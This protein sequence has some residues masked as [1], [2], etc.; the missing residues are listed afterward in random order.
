M[1]LVVVGAGLYGLAVARAALAAGHDVTVIEQG[2]APNP[3]AASV[4]RH[5]L[6]RYPYG[7]ER[8]YTAMVGEAFAAWEALWRSL[9]QRLYHETG[10][11]ALG[12]AESD[13]ADLSA[14]SLAALGLPFER[15]APESIQ[16]RFPHLT[17]DGLHQAL[18]LP[19]GGVLFAER[20]VAALAA[21]LRGRGRLIEG[22]AVTELDPVR[23]LARLAD[24]RCFGGDHLVVAAGPW[25]GRLVPRLAAALRPLRQVLVY[26]DG[27]AMMA[28]PWARAPMI[29]DIDPAAGFYA[30]PPVAGLPLKLGDHRVAGPAG[31][32]DREREASPADAAA[33]LA[34][35]RRRLRAFDTYRVAAIRTCYYTVA[36]DER[37]V[38]A[39]DGRALILSC[40]SGHGFKFGPL[41]AARVLACLEGRLPLDQLQRWAAGHLL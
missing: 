28:G 4:D 25:T 32:P 8:G 26:L 2:A 15:L 27:P 37:F 17:G 35:A 3:R 5:R 33:I 29:L 39:A 22:V 20:I 12:F 30:V 9:G 14:A 23:G 16:A 10:T 38:I 36:A 31:D 21:L 24:G 41:I 40:C 6:I 11:L 1:R 13:W 7:A 18:Y 34:A 19:S